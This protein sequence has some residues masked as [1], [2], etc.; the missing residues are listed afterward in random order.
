MNDFNL[1]RYLIEDRLTSSER[2]DINENEDKEE[3]GFFFPPM[4]GGISDKGKV[5]DL[6]NKNGIDYTDGGMYVIDFKGKNVNWKD[7]MNLLND[8][9]IH[10]GQTY[11]YRGGK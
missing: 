7:I 6:L 11:T 4:R 2:F 5:E 10:S 8:S 1:K 3:F 9:G